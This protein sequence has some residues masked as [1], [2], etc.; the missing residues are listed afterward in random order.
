[1]R[2]AVTLDDKYTETSGRIYLNGMHALVRIPLMQFELDRAAGLKTAT[3]I[4]GYRGSPLGGLDQALAAAKKFTG[5]HEIKFVPAVNEDLGATAVWGSQQLNLGPGSRYD[6]IVGMWYGKGPGVDRSI[7]VLKHANAA[8]SSKHGGVL[9]LAGDDHACKSSTFP[10]QS[11]QAFMHAMIPVLHPAGIDDALNLGLHGIAMSRY[12]GAWTAFKVISD[13]ADSSASVNTDPFAL[14]FNRPT[15]FEMPKDGLNIRWYDPPVAQEERL[16]NW[17]LPAAQAYARANGLDR[18]TLN[19]AK[20]RIAIVATGKAWMD[21]M[22][23]LDDL[24]IPKKRAEEMGIAVYKVALVWPLEPQGILRLASEVE[25]LFVVEEKRGVIEEQIKKYLFNLPAD[26]RPRVTGKTDERGAPLLPETYELSPGQIAD[27]LLKRLAPLTD[28]SS[29]TDRMAIIHKNF[30]LKGQPS[31]VVRMPWY[32]SGCPHNTSTVVPEGSRALAGIGCH[33]MAMWMDRSTYMFTQMGG[34]GVPWVGQQPFT[35]EKHVFSNLGDGTYFHSGL[36]AI[37][38]SIAAK[39][40]ITYKILYNDAVAMTG[41]Q[42][43]DGQLTVPMVAHQV[44]AEGA[45]TIYIVSDEPW[46]Y[47]NRSEFPPGIIIDHRDNLDQIQRT[48]RET[49]GVTIMIYDQTCAAEKR[50]RRK[51]GLMEDPAKRVIVNERACEGCGDCGKKSNCLSIAPVE[52]EFGRKRQIDQSTCNKDFSCV[53]GFC[54]SFVTVLGGGLKKP[55]VA[56]VGDDVADFFKA[57]PSPVIQEMTSPVAI[58]VTGVGGTGIVT[59]GA[60]IA[61][62]AHIENK[63]ATTMDQTGLAQKG[64]AVTSHI[65]IAKTPEDINTVRIGIAGA[66]VIIGADMLVTADGDCLS[67][68]RPAGTMEKET[69]VILNT[70]KTQ[71]GEFTRKADWNIPGKQ[72]VSSIANMCGDKNLVTLEAT[73]I[74]TALSGDSIATNMFM[75][76]FAWQK[77]YIPLSEAAL[78][79]AIELNGVGVKMNQQAFAWGRRAAWNLE[80]VQE[81]SMPKKTADG[82]DRH[83]Q[84][85][86]TLEEVIDRRMMSLTGYQNS[87]YAD[88]YKKLVDA[89]RE[90][91]IRVRGNPGKLTETVARYYYKLMA[92][93][94]EYEVARLY[95]DGQF[96]SQLKNTFEG[97]VK[98]KFNLAPPLLAKRDPVT[99]QLQKMEF[100]QWILPLF[101]VMAKMKPLRGTPLDIFGYTAERKMERQLITDYKNTIKDLLQKLDNR[102][103]SFA[104]DIAAIPEH[105]RGYGHVKEDHLKKAK[106][107]EADLLVKFNNPPAPEQKKAA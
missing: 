55:E 41:G 94:D 80:K 87:S 105:I 93:K 62:A 12:S 57:M 92:Y 84:I 102:N 31:P 58:L 72:V 73:Q 100:G 82:S 19:P 103:Y 2:D 9:A 69:K 68:I 61:M 104:C 66:D 90:A 20:K 26:K 98:L 78:M 89:V 16:V 3:F 79:K 54:P 34:E 51:R 101:R 48:L 77:G 28:T 71:T 27:A 8:G 76:G 65:R 25:E 35:D 67:K 38:Q 95:T 96:L 49:P 86:T 6:G 1:M 91:E 106:L 15:D 88:K 11:E 59:I 21:T 64:G 40:N 99:G 60:I 17:K 70:Q 5:P 33:Y 23:A 39:S 46:K 10:H 75:L 52:T 14:T 107:A 85:S 63:G 36:L 22:Q 53:K 29:F 47:T 18:L 97:D 24:G 4:S 45:K 56:K 43:V 50:R 83:R 42:P 44:Y 37:R 7:D 74:A 32:C 30:D 13:F 81:L